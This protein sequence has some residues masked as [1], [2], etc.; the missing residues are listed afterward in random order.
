MVRTCVAVVVIHP[1]ERHRHRGIA[2]DR[3]NTG[4]D[5]GGDAPSGAANSAS[6]LSEELH[7]ENVIRGV[8]EVLCTNRETAKRILAMRPGL[9][10]LPDVPTYMR[11][12]VSRV[13]MK[14]S[15]PIRI[16]CQM[17]V[18]NPAIAFDL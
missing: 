14:E 11:S 12:R 6:A 4:G 1:V 2:A 3:A 13:A 5:S 15:V 17:I 10:L 9:M 8:A 16:A 18:Q 7:K